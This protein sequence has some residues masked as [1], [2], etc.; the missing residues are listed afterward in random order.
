MKRQRFAGGDE[1]R[2][3]L[4]LSDHFVFADDAYAAL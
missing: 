4:I 2:R 1:V 3:L